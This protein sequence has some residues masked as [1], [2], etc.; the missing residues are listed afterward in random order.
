[1]IPGFVATDAFEETKD[2]YWFFDIV[3]IEVS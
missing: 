3:F 1:L 2:S